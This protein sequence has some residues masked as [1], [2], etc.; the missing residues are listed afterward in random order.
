[1]NPE[2]TPNPSKLH[3]VETKDLNF[4]AYLSVSGHPFRGIRYESGVC[5]WTFST[6]EDREAMWY[7]FLASPLQIPAAKYAAEIRDLKRQAMR[8]R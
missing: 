4:A 3:E 2:N 5:Y 8:R 1:M 6:P 7:A